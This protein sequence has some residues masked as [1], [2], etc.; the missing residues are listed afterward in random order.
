MKN[1]IVLS[2]AVVFLLVAGLCAQDADSAEAEP[3]TISWQADFDSARTLAV[4]EDRYMLIEFY[5]DW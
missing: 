5:T 2:L 1:L 3:D 4:E